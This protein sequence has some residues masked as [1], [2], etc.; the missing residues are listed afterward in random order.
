MQTVKKPTEQNEKEQQIGRLTK[1]DLEKM[2]R[3]EKERTLIQEDDV[4]I[5]NKNMIQNA[6]KRFT[7]KFVL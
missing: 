6:S 5:H 7:I 3:Q 2:G 1:G 4:V